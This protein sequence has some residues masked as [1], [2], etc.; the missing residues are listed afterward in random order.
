[1]SDVPFLGTGWSFPP[2]FDKGG[3]TVEVLSDEGDIRSSLE[4]LLSTSTGERIMQ[5]KYGCD[6]KRF[7]FEPLN[8]SMKTLI[9]DLVKK[10]IL[11]FEPRV[12][13]EDISLVT[14]DNNGVLVITVEYTIISTNTRNNLVFP[15][16]IKEGTNIS[17]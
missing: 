11:Y 1:M 8:T 5:P 16:Y 13:L 15:Y 2:T 12:K 7:L 9:K 14:D 3:A 17:K 6:L 10:S 4:I